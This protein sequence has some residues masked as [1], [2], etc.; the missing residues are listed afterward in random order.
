MHPLLRRQLRRAGLDPQAAPDRES[1]AAFLERVDAFYRQSEEDRYLLE[2][3]MQLS[4]EEMRE[5]TD[6]LEASRNRLSSMVEHLAEGLVLLDAHGSILLAN[7]EAARLLRSTVEDLAGRPIASLTD[8][9]LPWPPPAAIRDESASVRCDDGTSLHMALALNPIQVGQRFQGATLSFRDVSELERARTEALEASRAKA[10]F[11]ANVSHEIRTPMSAILGF[12]EMLR[13]E[14]TPGTQSSALIDS[15]QNN[16]E[17]LL[18]LLN[19][20]L[21]LSK[22]ESGRLECEAVPV[23]LGHLLEGVLELS[24]P[25]AARKKLEIETTGFTPELEVIHT[26]PMRLRQI[27]VNVVGNAVKFTLEGRIDLRIAK[28]D[29]PSTLVIEVED[30]GI[31]IPPETLERIFEPFHQ[32]DTSMTRRFG[33]TGLG[34]SLSRQ[35]A[36]LLGGSLTA[37]STPG[38]GSCFRLE[39][40]NAIRPRL[41]KRAHGS[42][43]THAKI[44]RL[45]APD[46]SELH[47][48]LERVGADVTCVETLDQ[49]CEHLAAA[50]DTELLL[51]DLAQTGLDLPA[52]LPQLRKHAPRAAILSLGGGWLPDERR[53]ALDAGCD[54]HL[55]APVTT[56]ALV[57]TC[58]RHLGLGTDRSHAA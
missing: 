41:R 36:R 28:G 3:S 18:G 30:T 26:D 2:R 15:I 7:P 4:S 10:Q 40:A 42:P 14:C 21:D 57:A 23:E 33:G 27:L 32:A 39:L 53:R 25:I 11:L 37:T 29:E 56:S 17:H 20:I 9:P 12:A 16:G 8:P 44:L 6:S 31:G 48:E 47:T 38:L 5:L 19:D 45:G 43:L 54:D 49:A 46:E 22:I 50:K 55:D 51:L 52:A 35:L 13:V 34:L 1:W 24:R 58:I